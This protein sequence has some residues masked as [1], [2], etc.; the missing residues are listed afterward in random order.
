MAAEK[1]FNH[2]LPVTSGGVSAYARGV[3]SEMSSMN[4]IRTYIRRSV[5]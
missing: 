1:R 3:F 4:L 5:P 2:C